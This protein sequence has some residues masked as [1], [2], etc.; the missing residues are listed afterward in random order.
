MA[1]ADFAQEMTCRAKA[2][3]VSFGERMSTRIFAA[4]LRFIGVDAKNYDAFD[5][6]MVTTE[7]PLDGEVVPE[8]YSLLRQSF[9]CQLDHIPIVTGFL[10]QGYESGVIT[11]LGRGGSD[12]TATALAAA[13]GLPEVTVWKDVDGV[14]SGDPRMVENAVTVPTLTYDEA[15]EIAYFGSPVLH[16]RAMCVLFLPLRQRM[17]LV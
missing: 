11:T 14:L 8:A 2:N 1:V 6:G 13:L 16:P 17:I 5:A 4:H 3:L 12:L 10:G 9:G 7:D 15:T